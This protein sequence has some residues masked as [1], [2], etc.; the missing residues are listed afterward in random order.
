MTVTDN[1]RGELWRP[2]SDM[3]LVLAVITHADLADPIR[4]VNDRVN[5][6]SNGETYIGFPFEPVVPDEREDAP[7]KARIR[8]SNVSREIGQVIR[9]LTSAA[10]ITFSIVWPDTPDTIEIE[11]PPLL[12][13]NV[14]YNAASIEGDLEAENLTLEPFPAHTFSPVSF[15]GLIQ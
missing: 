4:V 2:E 11:Y 8:I 5:L 14:T 15:P 9:Q 13:R 6:V 10:T 3:P 7:P 1:V 12:L